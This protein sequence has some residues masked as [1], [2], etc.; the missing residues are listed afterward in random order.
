MFCPS[1]CLGAG[2][3]VPPGCLPWGAPLGAPLQA[4]ASCGDLGLLRAGSAHGA[5]PMPVLLLAC[6]LQPCAAGA[7]VGCVCVC[8]GGDAC[9]AP[10][11]FPPWAQGGHSSSLTPRSRSQCAGSQC[12]PWLCDPVPKHEEGSGVVQ[13]M[14]AWLCSWGRGPAV[15][16]CTLARPPAGCGAWEERS[17]AE[18][19]CCPSSPVLSRRSPTAQAVVTAAWSVGPCGLAAAPCPRSATVQTSDLAQ[20]AGCCTA[21]CERPPPRGASPWRG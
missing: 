15:P 14:A 1:C 17:R 11:L 3:G 7:D 21:A 19:P 4:C 9:P 2:P 18:G 13:A 12:H 16:C 10:C 5:L 20:P 6:A 8:V